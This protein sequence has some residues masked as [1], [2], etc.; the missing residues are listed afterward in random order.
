MRELKLFLLHQYTVFFGNQISLKI[1]LLHYTYDFLAKVNFFITRPITF[2]K[3]KKTNLNKIGFHTMS[4]FLSTQKILSI[5]EKVNNLFNDPKKIITTLKSSGLIRL[6]NSLKEVPEL[7]DYLYSDEIKNYL[8][9]YYGSNYRIYSSD[10]YRTI[11]SNKLN[12]EKDFSSLLWH[13]DNSP[14]NLMKVM[15]YINDVSIKNGAISFV[16]KPIS[17]ELKKKG[18][19]DR[20]NPNI[21][22]HIEKIEK[23]NVYL[24]GDSGTILFFSVHDCIHKATLPSEGHRDVAV[25]L[26]QPSIK[27]NSRIKD[28]QKETLSKNYGYCIN[29]F[30]S[31]PLRYGDE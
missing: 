28:F 8:T 9:L 29:P 1:N 25:F 26:I 3:S 30:F 18:Y 22:P 4:P 16:P 6:K 13:F 14:K 11:P 21:A 31:T 20:Y 2:F 19:W 5:K 24:E 23:N 17:R 7:E 15:I 12:K 10:L 27:E